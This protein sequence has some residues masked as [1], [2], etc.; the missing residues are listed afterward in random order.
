MQIDLERGTTTSHPS[1]TFWD[2]LI[3]CRY[4]LILFGLS[5]HIQFIENQLSQQSNG[6]PEYKALMTLKEQK[7]KRNG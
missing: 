5:Q 6:S 3:D 4:L 7:R 1:D 2:C